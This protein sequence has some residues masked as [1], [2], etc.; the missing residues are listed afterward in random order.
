LTITVLKDNFL[1]GDFQGEKVTVED[2]DQFDIETLVASLELLTGQ[3]QD[4]KA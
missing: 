4:P 3:R 1:S 2:L